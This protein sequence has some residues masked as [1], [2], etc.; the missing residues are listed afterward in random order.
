MPPTPAPGTQSFTR[1]EPAMQRA[2]QA[3][4]RERVE[5]A[6]ALREKQT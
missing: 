3:F 5:R 2:S 4:P 6:I 1:D